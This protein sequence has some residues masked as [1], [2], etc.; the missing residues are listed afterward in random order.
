MDI[1]GYQIERELARGGMA[2]VYVARQIALERRIALKVL[3]PSSAASQNFTQR[4]QRE[5]RL[6]AK[7]NHTHIVTVFDYGVHEQFYYLSME[8]LTKGTLMQQIQRGLTPVQSIKIIKAMARALDYAHGLRLIHRD[9]K[10]SNILFR[11]DWTPVLTDFG[12][13]RLED[14]SQQLTAAGQTLGTM[15]YMSPEQIRGQHLDR[16]TD[17]YSL[18]IVLYQMLTGTL[19][20]RGESYYEI[21]RQHISSPIPRLPAELQLFQPLIDRLLAKKPDD[22]FNDARALLSV[23]SD[24]EPTQPPTLP[25]PT[26]PTPLVPVPRSV[27]TPVVANGATQVLQP[28]KATTRTNAGRPVQRPA[29]P[30]RRWLLTGVAGLLLLTVGAGLAYQGYIQYQQYALVAPAPPAAPTIAPTIA[31]LLTTARQLQAEGRWQDSL[32]FIERGLTLVP[33]DA[34]LQQLR[35]TAQTELAQRQRQVETV[36]TEANALLAQGQRAEAL[37]RLLDGLRRLPNDPQL[38][39]LLRH[40]STGSSANPTPAPSAP[41]ATESLPALLT[42]A[43]IRLNAG[44]LFGPPGSNAYESYLTVLQAEPTDTR[45]RQGML[46]V[47]QTH[48]TAL[49]ERPLPLEEQG[50]LFDQVAQRITQA[51]D[52]ATDFAELRDLQTKVAQQRSELQQRLQT[53]QTL[54]ATARAQL[55]AARDDRSAAEQACAALRELMELDTADPTAG[56]LLNDAGCRPPDPEIERLLA[57]AEQQLA[58]RRY[59]TPRGDNA[60]ETYQSVLE[61]EPDNRAAQRGL[62]QIAEAYETLV[63]EKLAAR[64]VDDAIAQLA[65]GRLIAPAHDGLRQLLDTVVR[66]V[67]QPL[68][69]AISGQLSAAD[70]QLF[71]GYLRE[72]FEGYLQV[73]ALNPTNATA[74]RRL[75]NLARQRRGAGFFKDAQGIYSQWLQLSPGSADARQGLVD[76]A[77]DYARQLQ[78]KPDNA[79]TAAAL[80]AIEQQLQALLAQSPDDPVLRSG[81][82]T[83]AA[84]RN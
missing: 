71:G 66:D 4:F 62:A 69:R 37:V 22:R 34:E 41:A 12:I 56:T 39:A 84:T 49:A 45:A 63:R 81:L 29:R 26:L 40:I 11:S 36:L 73:L 32:A 15:L 2:T 43:D 74:Q 17:L 76:L 46:T 67:P 30:Y 6:V 47:F 18:G 82:D 55:I 23:L 10:P 35:D 20:Y 19:P 14:E 54:L 75:T 31:P 1:P 50:V 78:R 52:Q 80:T 64:R 61:R 42:A 33:G 38:Q 83:I 65:R 8:L 68:E 79:Q 16:R 5:G 44:Q 57:R 27:V 77:G 28:P 59:A 7:L 48:F 25:T 9:I 13:A 58:A 3:H 21:G 70:G 53:K 24:L 60:L 72:A 51:L